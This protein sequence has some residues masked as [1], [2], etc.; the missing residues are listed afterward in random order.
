MLLSPGDKGAVMTERFAFNYRSGTSVLHELDVRFKLVFIVIISLASLKAGIPALAALTLVLVMLLIH[1]GPAV[2]SILKLLRY[3]SFFLVLIFIA[4]ALSTPG[5]PVLE[6]KTVS[7]TREGMYGGAVV[8]W[9]LAVVITIGLLLV[10][11]TRP[12]EIKA[13]VEWYLRPVPF[14]P[15]KKVSIMM[16]LIIRFIPVIFDQAKETADAQRAR[17]VEI[18]KNP[19]YRLRKLLIPLMRRIFARADK[20]A[21]AMEARCYS[22]NRTDPE[23]KSRQADW[24]ALGVVIASCFVMVAI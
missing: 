3:V 9:R 14:F 22:E 21:D 16:S 11:T 4:R 1:A 12:S 19:V 8:C 5:S 13:A 18:R 23:L 7:V 20:L 10:S 6:Y 24:V 15:E 2:N 17:G